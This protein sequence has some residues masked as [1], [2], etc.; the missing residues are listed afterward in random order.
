MASHAYLINVGR[1]L[2]VDTEAVVEALR[3]DSV[4]GVALDV[5]DPEPLPQSH[6]LWS[7]PRAM[8]TPHVA[9]TPGRL[10]FEMPDHIEENVRRF[11]AGRPLLAVVD[12][13][14]GY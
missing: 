3:R 4:A 6:A 11:L 2:V 7:D 5:V 13:D 14:L 1:G 9:N 12:P 10:D 8:I